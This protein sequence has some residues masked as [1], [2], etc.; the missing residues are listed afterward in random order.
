MSERDGNSRKITINEVA[1]ALGVSATTVSR[2]LSGKGRISEETR[3]RVLE[4]AK[5]QG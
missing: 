4:Y 1:E 2:A 3:Q 5:D